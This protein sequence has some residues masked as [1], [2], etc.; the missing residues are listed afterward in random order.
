MRQRKLGK[1]GPVV[2]ALGLG[3]MGISGM[4]GPSDRSES[5]ATIHA[6]LDAGITLIDTVDSASTACPVVGS[7]TKKMVL[8][9]RARGGIVVAFSGKTALGAGS[10]LGAWDR[11]KTVTVASDP[12]S[13]FRLKTQPL[14]NWNRA[15]L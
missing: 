14:S 13:P 3:V 9:V 10:R 11:E 2:S 6:A 4:Y 12:N 1:N 8:P 15:E 7:K 5:I